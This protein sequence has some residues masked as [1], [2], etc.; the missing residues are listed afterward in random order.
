LRELKELPELVIASSRKKKRDFLE[1]KKQK[2]IRK[3]RP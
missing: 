2:R 3:K 1:A